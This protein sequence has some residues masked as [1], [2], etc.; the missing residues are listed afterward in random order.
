MTFDKLLEKMTIID[1]IIFV[2]FLS[3][4]GGSLWNMVKVLVSVP[5][6]GLAVLAVHQGKSAEYECIKN[7]LEKERK[8]LQKQGLYTGLKQALKGIRLNYLF[9]VILVIIWN[10]GIFIIMALLTMQYFD[11]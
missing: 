6:F 5:V 11:L 8:S 9:S 1:T 7:A 3:I 10:I 4:L 2:I